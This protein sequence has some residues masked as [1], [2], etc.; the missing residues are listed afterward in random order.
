MNI[1]KHNHKS[2]INNNKNINVYTNS[3]SKITNIDK[4]NNSNSN[5]KFKNLLN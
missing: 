2:I 3:Y 4:I 1:N 5:T